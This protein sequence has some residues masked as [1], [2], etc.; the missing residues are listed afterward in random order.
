MCRK[1]PPAWPCIHEVNLFPGEIFWGTWNA[2]GKPPGEVEECGADGGQRIEDWD[3]QIFVD[4]V[5]GGGMCQAL[6]E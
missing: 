4:N 5:C 1:E 3:P 6:H 2:R